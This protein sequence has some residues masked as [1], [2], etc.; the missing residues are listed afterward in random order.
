ML[1]KEKHLNGIKSGKISLAFRRWKKASVLKGSLQKTAIGLV[2]VDDICVVKEKEISEK[3]A[4]QAGFSNKEE[5]LNSLVSD[6]TAKIF[7]INL[8]YYGDDPRI[9]LREQTE[10]SDAD[11]L[12]LQNKVERLDQF[13]SHG[14]WTEKVL[15]AIKKNPKV[16]AIEIARLTNFEKDWLKI[17]IRKLKNL[18]LTISHEIG[19]EVS[20]RGNMFLEKNRRKTKERKE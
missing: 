1:F 16:R 20:A 12:K 10:L 13:G 17:N 2:R 19:Y 5:L 18:G 15:L 6:D 7:R 8:S 9:E 11:F 14:P 3:D 4:A